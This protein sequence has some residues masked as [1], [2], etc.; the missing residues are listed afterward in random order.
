M[1]LLTLTVNARP[2]TGEVADGATLLDVLRDA[3]RLTGAKYGCG[4]GRCGSCTVLVAGQPVRACVT[5]AT[6]ITAPIV[7]IEGVADADRL[8]PVQQAFLEAQA[9]QCGFCT[10]GMILGAIHLLSTRP[11]PTEAEIREALDAHVC[12]CGAYPRIVAAVRAAAAL[13]AGQGRP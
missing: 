9:F 5:Q 10:P 3:L 8:H 11:R 6:A 4:E 12:R 13:S 2:W 1:P 7:T